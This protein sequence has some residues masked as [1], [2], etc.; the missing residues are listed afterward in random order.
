MTVSV[1]KNVKPEPLS[2][3]QLLNICFNEVNTMLQFCRAQWH[4]TV[5]TPTSSK[6]VNLRDEWGRRK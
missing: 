1:I 4:S 3:T 6:D 5:M 2:Y